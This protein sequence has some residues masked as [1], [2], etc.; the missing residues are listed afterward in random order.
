MGSKLAQWVLGLRDGFWACATARLVAVR[1]VMAIRSRNTINSIVW[2]VLGHEYAGHCHN[3]QVMMHDTDLGIA[4]F[5]GGRF[6]LKKAWVV[7][8]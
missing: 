1:L 8:L 6:V 3:M 7:D 5:S 4:S 2:E